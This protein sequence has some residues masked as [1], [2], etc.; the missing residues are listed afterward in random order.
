MQKKAMEK[1]THHK[2]LIAKCERKNPV[3][4]IGNIENEEM[5][6]R[7]TRMGM[8]ENNKLK[9]DKEYMINNTIFD[10]V[11]MHYID[12]LSVGPSNK[13]KLFIMKKT[14]KI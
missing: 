9:E 10:A 3:Y 6:A 8:L 5:K 12:K 7:L 11:D 1:Q 4:G 14:E 13:L 2:T